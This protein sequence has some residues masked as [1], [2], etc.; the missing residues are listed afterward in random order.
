MNDVRP[1]VLKLHVFETFPYEEL[2]IILDNI[3]A[4]GY[5]ITVVDN[6]NFVI[7]KVK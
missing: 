1:Q 7:E 2:K 6:G 5:D 3:Q 4:L